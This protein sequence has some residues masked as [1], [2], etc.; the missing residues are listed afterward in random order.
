MKEFD[1]TD[2]TVRI[3]GGAAAAFIAAFGPYRARGEKVILRVI[4]INEISENSDAPIPLDRFLAAMRELQHQFGPAF[5]RKIGDLAFDT[6]KMPPGLDTIEKAIGVMDQAYQM[7]HIDADGKIGGYVWTRN[8]GNSGV[9]RCDNPYPCAF[10]F[11][12]LESIARRFESAG[13]VTHVDGPCRH[14]DGDTCSYLVEW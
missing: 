7:N 4:G 14:K 9:M 11:G 3:R 13:R 5:M 8:E 6:A 10:D 12:L 2:P 1:F